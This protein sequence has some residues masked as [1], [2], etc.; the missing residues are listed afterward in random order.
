MLWL[1][2]YLWGCLVAFI[3]LIA[4]YRD[5]DGN[6][7]WVELVVSI[8]LSAFSWLIALAL[9]IGMN[10]KNAEDHRKDNDDKDFFGDNL[11]GT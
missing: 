11:A 10:I 1:K 4:I 9:F 6:I 8:F 5:A 3:E 2:I 7:N